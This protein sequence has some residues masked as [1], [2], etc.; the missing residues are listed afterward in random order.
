M[1]TATI[2]HGKLAGEGFELNDEILTGRLAAW[3]ST[4]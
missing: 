3:S 4:C 2:S 1:L